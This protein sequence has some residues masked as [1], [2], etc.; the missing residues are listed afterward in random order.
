MRFLSSG[1]TCHVHFQLA[2]ARLV[3]HADLN[4]DGKES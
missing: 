2:P 3:A 4:G 1:I